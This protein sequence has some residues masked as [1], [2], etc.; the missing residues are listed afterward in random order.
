[1][2]PITRTPNEPHNFRTDGEADDNVPQG[3]SRGCCAEAIAFVLD[4]SALGIIA[5]LRQALGLQ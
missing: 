1:M 4:I 3:A 2:F 5:L